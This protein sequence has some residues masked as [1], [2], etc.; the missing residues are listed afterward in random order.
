MISISQWLCVFSDL[1]LLLLVICDL[2]LLLLKGAVTELISSSACILIS[3]CV[4]PVVFI[5]AT[6]QHKD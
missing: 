4:A 1:Y 5:W 3:I 2:V 6:K